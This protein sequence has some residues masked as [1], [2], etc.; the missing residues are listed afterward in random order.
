MSLLKIQLSIQAYGY[1]VYSF[2]LL[3][4]VGQDGCKSSERIHYV[5]GLGW[6][7]LSS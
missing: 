5:L 2:N 1:F 7:Y 6:Y 4:A 3:F